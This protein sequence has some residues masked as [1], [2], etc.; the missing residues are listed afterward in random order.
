MRHRPVLRRRCTA[1]R[2]QRFDESWGLLVGGPPLHRLRGA[3]TMAR[4]L[5]Q[6]CP[7]GMARRCGDLQ[8]APPGGGGGKQW[9]ACCISYAPEAWRAAAATFSVPAW[10]GLRA[11]GPYFID[12]ET[13]LSAVLPVD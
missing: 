2:W 3:Q 4:L 9:P 10:G 12:V 13:S 5:Y 11:K 8:R 7:R 6:L 1:G